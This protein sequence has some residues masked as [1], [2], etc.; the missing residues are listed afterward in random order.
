VDGLLIEHSGGDGV[1]PYCGLRT[2]DWL[3]THY[4]T[5]EEELYDIRADPYELVNVVADNASEANRLRLETQA[6]CVP[7]P[8]GFSWV[9]PRAERVP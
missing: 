1:P 6:L 4:A 2:L 9:A 3:Y 7:L 5:G 8:P